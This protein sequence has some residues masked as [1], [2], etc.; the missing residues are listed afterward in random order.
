MTRKLMGR[1]RGM[2][3]VFDDNGNLIPCTVIELEKNVVT[4]IKTVES[5][6]YTAVQIGCEKVKAKDPRTQESRT[7]KP[8]RGHFAKHGVEPR[9]NL[10]E[11]RVDDVENFEVGQ[12][13]GLEI[14]KDVEFV[15]VTGTSKGK[16][17]QG[18]MKL[19]NYSGGPASHGSKFHRRRGSQGMRT[20]PGRCF[21]GD[22]RP[23]RMGNR[24][25][26]TQ[27]LKVVRIDE[28]EKLLLVCG[29]VPGATDGLVCVSLAMKKPTKAK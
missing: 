6:G 27:S 28:E 5:D 15:D 12:E 13:I 10:C 22:K 21:P 24:Q 19:H 9:K 2:A 23:G 17:F 8:L 25:V 29:S 14:F 16:G 11:C 7:S 3:H 20:T 18:V 1:K 26:T 4:Q